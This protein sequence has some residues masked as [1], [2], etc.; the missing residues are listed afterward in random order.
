M[1]ASIPVTPWVIVMAI[2]YGMGRR[3]YANW[4]AASLAQQHWDSLTER[5]RHSIRLDASGLVGLEAE[6][7]AWLADR[8]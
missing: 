3:T 4:D 5:D 7:W 8:P 1:T 2:R 6:P